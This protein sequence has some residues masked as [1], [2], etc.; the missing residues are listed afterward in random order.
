M[1]PATQ[2]RPEDIERLTDDEEARLEAIL[3]APEPVSFREFVDEVFPGFTWYWHCT[4]LAE[5][6]QQVAEGDLDRLMVFEPPRHGKSELISRLF[7]AYHM[8]RHPE[9]NVGITSYGARL[10]ERDLSTEARRYYRRFGGEVSEEASAK[11]QWKNTRGGEVWAAGVGGGITGSGF[12][13]GIIDDPIKGAKEA[14]SEKDRQTRRDWYD[15]EF[16]T[17]EEPGGS[18]VIVMTR[19]REDDLCGWLLDR[20]ESQPQ[21]WHIVHFEAIRDELPEYPDTCTVEEDPRD[22]GEPLC[23]E[24]K[25]L[26]DLEHLRETNA[27]YF[28]AQ[29][30]GRPRPREGGLFKRD[31]FKIKD[32]VPDGG[33]V[34]RYWDRAGTEEGGDYTVGVRARLVEV[35]DGDTRFYVE[36][37]VRGQWGP[38]RREEEFSD[39]IEIDGPKIRQWIEEE[40]GSSGKDAVRATAKRN[41]GFPIRG[42]R[43]TGTTGGKETRADPLAS[44]GAT[45]GIYLKRASWNHDFIRELTGFPHGRHDDQ[46]DAASGAYRKLAVERSGKRSADDMTIKW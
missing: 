39:T 36:D 8:Y 15:S 14:K 4:V 3:Q 11:K 29:F 5:R 17:R 34:V 42:D 32:E 38:D 26:G 40:P 28:A 44:W 2:V 6:L 33:R 21:H 43:V 45:S 22:P 25:P 23:P 18:Q 30:Q 31:Y 46:V 10:A 24:R 19:W 20:E 12:D 35:E 7:P 41:P 1:S 27:Y 16:R 37:V 9:R 13:V